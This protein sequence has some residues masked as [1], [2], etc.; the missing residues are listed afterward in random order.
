MMMANKRSPGK[1]NNDCRTDEALNFLVI[2][3]RNVGI[4]RVELM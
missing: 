3:N 2:N 4:T 1:I